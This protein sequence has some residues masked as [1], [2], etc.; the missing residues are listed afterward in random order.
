MPIIDAHLHLWDVERLHYHWLTPDDPLHRAVTASEIAPLMSDARV[1][2]AL[3]VEAANSSAEIPYLLELADA[4][5]WIAGIIPWASVEDPPPATVISRLSGVRL[6]WLQPDMQ[7]VVPV[8]V[9]EHHLPCDIIAGQDAYGTAAAIARSAPE[10]TFVL[11]HFGLPTMRPGA[12]QP[13]AEQIARLADV[14]NLVMK[15]SG[16]TTSADPRPLQ[17]E[18]LRT[19][20][21]EAIRLFGTGRL[22]WGSNYPISLRAGGYA[23]DIALM[24][25]ATAHLS[26]YAQAEIFGGTAARVYR[27]GAL[28]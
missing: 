10:L 11:A 25:A 6:P 3:L 16:H 21:D 9:R 20:V 17:A 1:S 14:P 24:R 28:S 15:L 2:H 7:A 12:A 23:D 19:F 26:N 18:T 5:P 4:H 27:L 13:W 8:I 22:M